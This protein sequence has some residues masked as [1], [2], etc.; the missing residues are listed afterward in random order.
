[1]NRQFWPQR[2]NGISL[3]N[4]TVEKN[5]EFNASVNH[6]A[7]YGVFDA[8]NEISTSQNVHASSYFLSGVQIDQNLWKKF[9][10]VNLLPAK[11][12]Y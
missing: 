9:F 10:S 4:I 12:L 3:W 6:S 8:K 7:L 5:Y 1:M 2:K 11:H